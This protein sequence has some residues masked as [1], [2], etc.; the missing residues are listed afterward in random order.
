MSRFCASKTTHLI[1]KYFWTTPV[2][3]KDS[4][5]LHFKCC[6]H[7]NYYYYCL[8]KKSCIIFFIIYA[9]ERPKHTVSTE[10][11]METTYRSSIPNNRLIYM[12]CKLSRRVQRKPFS[13]WISKVVK[14]K[15]ETELSFFN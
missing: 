12:H 7:N 4:L 6:N 5:F 9:L 3:N 1:S 11:R 13:L 8:R 10:E 2:G 14:D 15:V